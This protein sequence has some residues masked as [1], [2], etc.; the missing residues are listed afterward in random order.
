MFRLAET[1]TSLVAVVSTR[2]TSL[3]PSAP[4]GCPRPRQNKIAPCASLRG[5]IQRRCAPFPFIPGAGRPL[6]GGRPPTAGCVVGP[7]DLGGPGE[8]IPSVL[9]SHGGVLGAHHA[10]VSSSSEL[11]PAGVLSSPVEASRHIVFMCEQCVRPFFSH[12]EHRGHVPGWTIYL[13]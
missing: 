3:P 8:G 13:S 5:R 6:R 9:S 12:P 7:G 2:D 11:V 10:M 1:S 4:G